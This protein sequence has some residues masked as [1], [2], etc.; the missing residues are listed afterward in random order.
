MW[1]DPDCSFFGFFKFLFAAIPFVIYGT[2]AV[3]LLLLVVPLWI[4]FTKAGKPGWAAIIPF[5][6]IIVLLEIVGRP[7]W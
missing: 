2:L 5:Y 4:I 3:I 6:N 7:L 1:P